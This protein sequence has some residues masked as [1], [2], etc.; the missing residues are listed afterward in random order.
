MKL[1]DGFS[2]MP[3]CK[4]SGLSGNLQLAEI[5]LSS[6]AAEATVSH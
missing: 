1:V 6:E 5:S 3:L 4:V 2:F